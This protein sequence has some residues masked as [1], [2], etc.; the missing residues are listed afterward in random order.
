MDNR[1][2]QIIK[3]PQT[4][5]GNHESVYRSWHILNYV[6][7]YLETHGKILDGRHFLTTI[8]FMDKHGTKRR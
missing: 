5:A 4:I 3:Y 2:E 6:K 1:I 7:D 8:D